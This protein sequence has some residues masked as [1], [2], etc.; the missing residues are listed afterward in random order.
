[1]RLAPLFLFLLVSSA[2]HAQSEGATPYPGEDRF[3]TIVL[4]AGERARYEFLSEADRRV[5]QRTHW[6]RLD[7][8]PAT[9][10]N[11]REME[12][13]R[14]VV[15]AIEKFRGR[16]GRFVWDDRA[17]AWIRFGPP[18]GAASVRGSAAGGRLVPPREVWV[19]DDMLFWFEDPALSGA[20]SL[21]KSE[22]A[23]P[24]PEETAR[25]LESGEGLLRDLVGEENPE[26]ALSRALE[27]LGVAPERLE[28]LALRGR[29][30]WEDVPE[31]N[32]QATPA[33]GL[34]FDHD[35]SAFGRADELTDILVGI[36][37]PSA[38]LSPAIEIDAGGARTLRGEIRMALRDSTYAPLWRSRKPLTRRIQAGERAEDALLFVD[39]FAVKPGAY[40]LVLQVDD[41]V[42][43]E[44]GVAAEPLV[45]RSSPADR[46]LLSD[47][48]FA[49]KASSSFRDTGELLRGE[50]RIDPRPGG[51]FR[52][53]E[54][55]HAYFEACRLAP[56]RDGRFYCEITYALSG[57]M[58]GPFEAR[59]RGTEKGRLASGRAETR[60][61]VSREAKSPHAIA[62]E[63]SG[64]R[65]DTYTLTIEV[66]DLA[67]GG[68]ARA[69]GRFRIEE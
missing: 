29:D 53:G 58:Q 60:S 13:Q 41:L 16:F 24:I 38:E 7:P 35:V 65:P 22:G 48:L 44:R 66:K 18:L 28:G 11:E 68:T 43:G 62:I 3:F 9:E 49:E 46:L 26:S 64:L 23:A 59:F 27:N 8:T 5:F 50:Y 17:R 61:S 12:H 57:T 55:V 30:R 56:D 14:R 39:S 2:A 69:E 40:Q 54:P 21:G 6:G 10:E 19:Y 63:S 51:V 1:M 4:S 67:T 42:S 25:R 47:L 33:S 52:K 37:I 15:G 32:E 34:S 36:R 20:F 31:R 45:V